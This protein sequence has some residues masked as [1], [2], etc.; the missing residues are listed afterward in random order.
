MTK[1]TTQVRADTTGKPTTACSIAACPITAWLGLLYAASIATLMVSTSALWWSAAGRTFPLIPLFERFCDWPL[2]VDQ[3]STIGVGVGL[4]LVAT[5]SAAKLGSAASIEKA[6][7]LEGIGWRTGWLLAGLCA[8]LLVCLDQQRLQPWFYQLFL[9]SIVF[10]TCDRT[11]TLKLI[12]AL[13]ISVYFYSAVGKFDYQ[14]VNSVAPDFLRTLMS[15]IGQDWNALDDNQKFWCAVCL[16]TLELVLATA[17]CVSWAIYVPLR[18]LACVAAIA[19]HIGLALLFSTVGLG[20]SLGVVLWN[21]Q[22]AIQAW[23]LFGRWPEHT[24]QSHRIRP[25]NWLATAVIA[26]AVFMPLGERFGRWDHWPSWALYAPH[27]SRAEIYVASDSLGRL[28]SILGELVEAELADDGRAD[29]VVTLWYRLPIKEWCLAETG[30]PIYPQDR[31]GVGVGNYLRDVLGGYSIR[32]DLLGVAGRFDGQRPK[33]ERVLRPEDFV[34]LNK[35]FYLNTQ[36]RRKPES[37][38]AS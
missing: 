35:R 10:A 7:R 16:P 22:F 30:A 25:T 9:T 12:R 13:V 27:S 18:R 23:L 37:S 2:W 4:A 8:A 1:Q 6:T 17:L 14:F 32:V 24:N 21:I 5:S 31:L 33:L 20:H 38:D 26:A 28:P 29:D 3:L 11:S 19:F 15:W 36:P 34:A